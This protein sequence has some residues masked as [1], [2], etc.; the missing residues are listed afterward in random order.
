MTY[1]KKNN[2]P[3]MLGLKAAF[4]VAAVPGFFLHQKC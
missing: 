1:F 3:L 4:I 2:F